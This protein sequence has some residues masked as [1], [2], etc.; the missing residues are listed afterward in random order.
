MRRYLC[1]G[2]TYA[3]GR[4]DARTGDVRFGTYRLAGQSCRSACF[5][6]DKA[7]Y[8]RIFRKTYLVIGKPLSY[9]ECVG[10]GSR[11]KK[12]IAEYIFSKVCEPFATPFG[13]MKNYDKNR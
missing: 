13:D 12:E 9:E 6:R 1:T 8:A 3:P 2:N 4:A 5:D 7:A 11:T 10:N